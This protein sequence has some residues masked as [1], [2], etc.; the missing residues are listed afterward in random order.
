MPRDDHRTIDFSCAHIFPR[1][2]LIVVGD[3]GE[4]ADIDRDR[5]ERLV[6][7]QRLRAAVVVD[8]RQPCIADLATEGVAED[9]QLD[10]RKH[11][12]HHHQRR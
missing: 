11:H 8:D 7:L 2:L 9:D 12:R 6:D 4:G 10:Q 5:L 1:L 3:G